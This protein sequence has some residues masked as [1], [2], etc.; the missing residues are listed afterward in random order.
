MIH[1]P[2]AADTLLVPDVLDLAERICAQ[3]QTHAMR[4]SPEGTF[5]VYTTADVAMAVNR[6]GYLRKIFCQKLREGGLFAHNVVV[7]TLP[8][9]PVFGAMATVTLPKAKLAGYA[10]LPA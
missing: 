7:Q 1:K 9:S 4:P 6:R 2:Y 10:A 5:S 3:A 8:L